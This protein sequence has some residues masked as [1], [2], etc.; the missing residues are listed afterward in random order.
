MLAALA[1]S[2]A[3]LVPTFTF[4][5]LCGGFGWHLLRRLWPGS[6]NV[7]LGATLALW[8]LAMCA[9]FTVY[10]YGSRTDSRWGGRIGSRISVSHGLWALCLTGLSYVLVRTAL[11]RYHRGQRRLFYL[12]SAVIG[13]TLFIPALAWLLWSP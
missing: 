9:Y 3:V 6:Q 2:I 7:A 5:G 13:V 10:A 8:T 4:L 11:V 12:A 1:R